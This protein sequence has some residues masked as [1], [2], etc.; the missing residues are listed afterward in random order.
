MAHLVHVP[1][2]LRHANAWYWLVVA[3]GVAIVLAY[4]FFEFGPME[5]NGL[6]DMHVEWDFSA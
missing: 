3:F 2:T 4:L 6:T 1:E 5:T